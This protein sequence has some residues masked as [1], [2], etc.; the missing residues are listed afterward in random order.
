MADV[1]IDRVRRLF[2][3]NVFGTLAVTQQVLPRMVAKGAG[4]IIIVSSIAGV[5]VG[6]VVRS[7]LDDE[8]RVGGDGQGDARRVGARRAST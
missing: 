6:P 1:P 8:A 4:R 5:V 3:V 2:E 7:V